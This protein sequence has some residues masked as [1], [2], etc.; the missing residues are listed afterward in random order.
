MKFSID[1]NY[2]FRDGDKILQDIGAKRVTYEEWSQYEIRIDR[3]G[4]LSVIQKQLQTYD[5]LRY[6]TFI[7]DFE[8]DIANIYID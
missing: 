5:G 1:F 2:P 3:I 4:E 8:G 6:C 7:L